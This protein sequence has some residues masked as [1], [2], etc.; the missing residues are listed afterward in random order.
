MWP[1]PPSP[2]R[3]TPLFLQTGGYYY[4][5]YYPAWHLVPTRSPAGVTVTGADPF[6]RSVM[7]FN[8][9]ICWLASVFNFYLYHIP[10]WI[11]IPVT[12]STPTLAL[13]ADICR[14]GAL[15]AHKPAS[16]AS[17]VNEYTL[18]P[19]RRYLDATFC[20]TFQ[21][22]AKN[23]TDVQLVMRIVRC[24]IVYVFF[25]IRLYVYTF[26]RFVRF[27]VFTFI[28]LFTFIRFLFYPFFMFIR[29]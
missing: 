20:Y 28:R 10:I 1:T 21:A 25:L 14:V 22:M 23:G 17:K 11:Y 24:L 19:P 2:Q 15:S 16:S 5:T 26:V 12:G 13:R 6:R 9:H 8:T 3:Y 27:Y 7:T 29:L 4:D 18:I